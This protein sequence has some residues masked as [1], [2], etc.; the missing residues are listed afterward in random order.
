SWTVADTA[1]ATRG[2]LVMALVLDNTGSLTTNGGAT[3][4]KNAVPT[5][6]SYFDDTQDH[7]SLI[8]F[9]KKVGSTTYTESTVNFAMATNFKST[10]N[11]DVSGLSAGGGTFGTGGTYVAGYGPPIALADNQIAS[12]PIT[13]GANIVRVM[14]YFTDGLVNALQDSFTC[15]TDSTHTT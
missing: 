11:S 10:I 8:T 15:Y 13:G 14:V 1:V 2:K 9:G 12:V 4:V 5:F 7:A 6:V 3:A